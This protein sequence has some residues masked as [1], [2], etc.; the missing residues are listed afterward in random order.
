MNARASIKYLAAI[1]ATVGSFA[2]GV[3]H[4]QVGA[5]MPGINMNNSTGT[6]ASAST[7]AFQAAD[8]KMMERMQAPAYTGDA[9]KDFVD[10]MIPHHQGAI[11]MAEVELRYGKDPQLK[12]LARDIVKAQREEIATMKRWQSKHERK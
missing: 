12:K 5:S 4:A 7:S 8:K 3:T 6:Q 9:D 1:A 11:D 2:G 10:H